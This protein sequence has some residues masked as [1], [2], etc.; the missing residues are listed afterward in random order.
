MRPAPHRRLEILDQPGGG[1]VV[2]GAEVLTVLS[3]NEIIATMQ[4]GAR[5]RMVAFTKSNDESSRGHAIF[6]ITITK[7]DSVLQV[8]QQAQLYLVDLAGSEKADKTGIYMLPPSR[9]NL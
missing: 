3:S 2:T 4:R 8:S 5:N 9:L 7:H 1:V 6:L